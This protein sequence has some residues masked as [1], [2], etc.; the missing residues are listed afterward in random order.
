M[1]FR[2]AVNAKASRKALVPP[3]ATDR[4]PDERNNVAEPAPTEPADKKQEQE[5]TPKSKACEQEAA[6]PDVGGAPQTARGAKVG[7]SGA[8]ERISRTGLINFFA[9]P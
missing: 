6:K 3:P 1:C 9:D 2:V 4:P 7:R 8:S 5:A